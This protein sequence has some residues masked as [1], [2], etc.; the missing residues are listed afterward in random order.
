MLFYRCFSFIVCLIMITFS[1]SVLTAD[2]YLTETKKELILTA[3]EYL[4][5]DNFMLAREVLDSLIRSNP[6]DPIGY[7]YKAAVYL[8]EMTDTEKNLFPDHFKRLID[9]AAVL[10]EKNIDPA[11][12]TYSAWMYLCLGHSS[13]YKSLW[14]SRFGSFTSALK[15]G[16][17]AKSAYADGLAFDSTVFDLYGGLGMYH[18]W[19]SVKAG[20]LRWI[21]IF[22]NDKQKGI[23]ELYLTMDSS[24]ISKDIAHNALIW[25]WLDKKEYDSVIVICN[26]MLNI[27]PYG[28]M[29]L[30]PLARAYF[31]KK[32]YHKSLEIYLLLKKKIL[33]SPGNYFNL[34][35]CDYNLHRCY[36]EMKRDE[37]A[38]QIALELVDYYEKIPPKIR[39]RQR[40][41]IAYLKRTLNR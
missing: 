9:T 2:E 31:K 24:I 18:Y 27:Y 36:K 33:I 30:W 23:D 12:P 34:V 3:Q 8:G 13:A 16:L 25:I 39:W 11:Q 4:F 1:S 5:N 28:K 17:K 40:S 41:K 20:F 10:A 35:E 29:F 15:Y 7:L 22:K 6:D 19:K 32:I 14:E 37:K 26:E 38:K 21:G